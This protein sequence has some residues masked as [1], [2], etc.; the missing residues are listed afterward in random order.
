MPTS[1]A[2]TPRF[3]SFARD[4]IASGRYNNVSE[5]VRDGL[6]L[7]EDT[8]K[9]EAIKL[10]ALRDLAKAGV[11]ALNAGD[12]VEVRVAD[13]GEYIDSISSRRVRGSV[14]DQSARRRGT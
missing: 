14:R 13:L 8:I 3:E 4:Q 2:L 1:V 7:L 12:Y 10:R 5:V 11:D 9:T 6:R